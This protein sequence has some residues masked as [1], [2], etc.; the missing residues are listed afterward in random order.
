MQRWD[1]PQLLT[2]S[3]H[4]LSCLTYMLIIELSLLQM[5]YH[6][7]LHFLKHTG[8]MHTISSLNSPRQKQKILHLASD[9]YSYF[10]SKECVC[11]LEF[12]NRS[13][14]N[15]LCIK[16][17]HLSY[18]DWLI[19]NTIQL[20]AIC[21]VSDLVGNEFKLHQRTPV[22]SFQE[23]ETFTGWFQELIKHDL[24]KHKLLFS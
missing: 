24:H 14:Y 1:Q 12:H 10:Y 9:N 21:R 11:W 8:Y 22:I 4:S 5:F 18:I 20:P 7:Y 23:Q 3:E 13:V 17:V 2:V 19:R 15:R 16:S 6:L